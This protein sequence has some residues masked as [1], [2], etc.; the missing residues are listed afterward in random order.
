MVIRTVCDQV[1][2]M[3]ERTRL[4]NELR[5]REQTLERA[6]R[7]KDEFIATLAHELRNPLAPIRNAVSLMRRD[8]QPDGER[9]NGAAT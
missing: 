4:M 3:L 2:A 6:D 1:S 8:V 9:W 7:A 5:E